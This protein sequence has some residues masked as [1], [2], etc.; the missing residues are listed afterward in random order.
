M[1]A[2]SADN[3]AF[4]YPS[5]VKAVEGLSICVRHGEVYGLLGL[6]GA[7]KTS[8]IKMLATLLRPTSG[9]IRIFDLDTMERPAEI[10]RRI[11]V[12]PQENNLDT[13]LDVR[14]NLIFHCRYAGM[15]KKIYA[16]LVDEWLAL[17]G[18]EGKATES[19]LR[20]SGGTKRKAML[21]KAFLTGPELLILDEPTAGLDPDVRALLWDRVGEFRRNGGTVFLSTHYLEE[22]ERLCDRIGILHSGRVVAEGTVAD[23]AHWAGQAS[24]Q[25]GGVA[26]AFRRAVGGCL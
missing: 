22:A 17:L 24:A 2:V 8:V 10:K 6:N 12:V 4:V 18:L 13:Y 21:A 16:P 5:G 26:A 14:Q 1:A 9:S 25:Q 19:V 20:L 3:V 15:A 7:G 11:G 23:L